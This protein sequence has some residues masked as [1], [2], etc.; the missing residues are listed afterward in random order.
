MLEVCG[1]L[2]HDALQD[3]VALALMRRRDK[4]RFLDAELEIELGLMASD[5]EEVVFTAGRCGRRPRGGGD[6]RP[7]QDQSP[8][9]RSVSL[10]TD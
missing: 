5:V 9:R 1:R 4:V 6:L 10:A 2:L 7:R 3:P 8:P